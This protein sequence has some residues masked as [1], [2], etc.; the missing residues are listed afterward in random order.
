M[1]LAVR[2]EHLFLRDRSHTEAGQPGAAS[3]QDDHDADVTD[4]VSSLTRDYPPHKDGEAPSEHATVQKA[5]HVHR[6]L[7]HSLRQTGR[8]QSRHRVCFCQK[9]VKL[10]WSEITNKTIHQPA[11]HCDRMLALLP[12]Q[13]VSKYENG[14]LDVQ[15]PYL[16]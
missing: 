9:H 3:R 15:S 16:P 6:F 2:S 5:T 11:D 10:W 4:V 8:K 1:R 13:L 12:S 14:S 7:D